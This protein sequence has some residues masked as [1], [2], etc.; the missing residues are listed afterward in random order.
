MPFKYLFIKLYFICLMYP[1][2]QPFKHFPSRAKPNTRVAHTSPP[3]ALARSHSGSL[4]QH[5]FRENV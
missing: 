4:S 3:I 1:F 2:V 5:S